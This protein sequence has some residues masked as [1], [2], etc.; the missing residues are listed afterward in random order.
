MEEIF[1]QLLPP[2]QPL[3]YKVLLVTLGVAVGWMSLAALILGLFTLAH[4][5]LPSISYGNA[6]GLAGLFL[7]VVGTV[8]ILKE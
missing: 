4:P 7:L 1:N 5:I 8:A 3:G 6:L 2:K